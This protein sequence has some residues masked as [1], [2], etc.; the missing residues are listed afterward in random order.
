MRAELMC[1]EEGKGRDSVKVRIGFQ[2]FPCGAA[3]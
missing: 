1:V 2:E 3:C